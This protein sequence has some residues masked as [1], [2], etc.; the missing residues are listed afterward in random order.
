[1][2]QIVMYL[3]SNDA[4]V[5]YGHHDDPRPVLTVGAYYEVMTTEVYAWTT[6]LTLKG[7][8]GKFNSVVFENVE[9][10]G[11]P[12]PE[13]E[14]EPEAEP[15]ENAELEEALDYI[16]SLNEFW[17]WQRIHRNDEGQ[18]KDVQAFLQKHGRPFQKTEF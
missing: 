5:N 17:S 14:V 18:F 3:G 11:V 4:Q 13:P 16:A 7:I 9:L 1:M 2:A 15:E 6:Q 12:E 8:E 10:E